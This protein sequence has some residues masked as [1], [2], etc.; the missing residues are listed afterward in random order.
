[1]IRASAGIRSERA[2]ISPT[3]GGEV[4]RY[5]ARHGE[6]RVAK[7]VLISSVP[8]L[9]AQ[10]APIPGGLPKSVFADLQAQLAAN[11][12]EFYRAAGA[13]GVA[14]RRVRPSCGQREVG[15]TAC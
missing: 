2:C 11:R 1:M 10:T 13:A 9:L 7:A 12:S 8:P 4:V 6:S 15:R 14:G 5:I 3:G